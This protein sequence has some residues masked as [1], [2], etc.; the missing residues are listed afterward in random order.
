LIIF[1]GGPGSGKSTF[2]RKYFTKYNY[3]RISNDVSRFQEMGGLCR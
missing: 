2:W 1:V 3:K